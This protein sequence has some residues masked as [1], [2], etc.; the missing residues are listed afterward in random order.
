MKS[1]RRYYL[2]N[3]IIKNKKYI[4]GNILDIGGTKNSKNF[5]KSF[6]SKNCIIYHSS[7]SAISLSPILV[8]YLKSRE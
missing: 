7:S 2:E 8:I 6:L 3:L 4:Y 1:I 5:F